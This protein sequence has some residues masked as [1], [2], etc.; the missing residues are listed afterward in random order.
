MRKNLSTAFFLIMIATATLFTACDKSEDYKP[1]VQEATTSVFFAISNCYQATEFVDLV[2]TYT[3]LE[4]K[5]ASV[6]ITQT[7]YELRLSPIT[8]PYNRTFTLTGTRKNGVAVDENATYDLGYGAALVYEEKNADGS[9]NRTVYSPENK[10]AGKTTD[11]KGDKV[12]EYLT[13]HLI[14]S[15]SYTLNVK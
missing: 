6:T 15:H 9:I 12:E 3:D 2:L 13:K 4:G 11:L 5:S 8:L 10:G 1:P 7:P 14:G